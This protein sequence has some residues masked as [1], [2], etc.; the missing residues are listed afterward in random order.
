MNQP[1]EHL[2]IMGVAGCGKTTAAA[3][4]HRALGWPVAEAD[5][6]HP[7]ANIDKMSSGIPLD[8]DDRRPWLES[9]RDWMSEQ[10]ASGTKTIVTCSALK[11]A[12]RDLL[13]QADGRV[14][15]IHLVAEQEELRERMERRAGH[16]MPPA[17][18]PSQFATLEP[19]ED[20]EDGITV[21]SRATPEATFEAILAA[22]EAATPA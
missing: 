7:Q 9:L 12:Y 18:L 8:D 5:D 22:L 13:S 11:R 19:L 14:F 20:D 17:L 1:V 16:F 3:N 21:V 10:A 2:V 6:F 4:L 15:F